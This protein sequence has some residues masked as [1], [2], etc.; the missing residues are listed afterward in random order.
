MSEPPVWEPWRLLVAERLIAVDYVRWDRLVYYEGMLRVY[1]WIDREDG[2]SDFVLADF[3]L[4]PGPRIDV[5]AM[6]SS[7]EKSKEITAALRQKD[8][9][10][11][12]STCQR[13]EDFFGT[14][15]GVNCVRLDDERPKEP[16]TPK[17]RPRERVLLDGREFVV[18]HSSRL[19]RAAEGSTGWQY[20]LSED[21]SAAAALI[22]NPFPEE[23]LQKRMDA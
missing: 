6:T 23:S 17:F 18:M 11:A 9:G 8:P 7:A 20:A 13:V 14:L 3:W 12:H 22:G 21:G 10:D 16:P 1:G 5:G 15:A 2:R 19:D 4:Y